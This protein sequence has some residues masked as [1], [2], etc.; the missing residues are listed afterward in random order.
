MFSGMSAPTPTL[1]GDVFRWRTLRSHNKF[2]HS[3]HCSPWTRKYMF[4][5]MKQESV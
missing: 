2:H 1:R 3:T 4:E 5:T